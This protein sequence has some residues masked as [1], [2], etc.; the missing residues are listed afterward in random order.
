MTK[1]S[2]NTILRPS[3][4]KIKFDNS[5]IHGTGVFATAHISEGEI[6][7]IAP[8]ISIPKQQIRARDKLADYIF[9][10][11]NDDT[12]QLAQGL[13]SLFNHSE[14]PNMLVS[15]GIEPGVLSFHAIKD[16]KADEELTFLYA[17]DWF[18]S[19]GLVA[20]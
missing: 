11:S 3:T 12:Y 15:H 1:L 20:K 16:I 17:P 8:Y 5:P 9:D 13:G 19:R 10:S 7:E 18:Q 6:I 2:L 4:R 14:D